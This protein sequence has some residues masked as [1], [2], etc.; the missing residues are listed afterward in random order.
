MVDMSEALK[1]VIKSKHTF[2]VVGLPCHIQSITQ[3]LGDKKSRERC[4]VK[5]GLMGGKNVCSHA[6]LY[7]IGGEDLSDYQFRGRGWWEFETRRVHKNRVVYVPWQVA[8]FSLIWDNFL[9]MPDRCVICSDFTAEYSDIS[10]CDAWLKKYTNDQDGHSI[11]LTRNQK[12]DNLLRKMK[13]EDYIY[14]QDSDENAIYSSQFTQIDYKR[15]LFPLK[16]K[17]YQLLFRKFQYIRIRNISHVNISDWLAMIKHIL[18]NAMSLQLVR[19]DLYRFLP[20]NF[21]K[22]NRR[23][24]FQTLTAKAIH[25]FT[26]L[27]CFKY[28][29][30]KERRF[31]V[32]K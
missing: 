12:A 2:A 3:L 14:L 31:E 28:K 4:K 22:L 25:K 27:D 5:I 9:M 1:E 21:L 17:I 24:V 13:E 32:R 18:L 8:G 10:V 6:L 15:R 20:K 16:V 19:Y 7:E 29:N 23:F 26:R 11:I 30:F